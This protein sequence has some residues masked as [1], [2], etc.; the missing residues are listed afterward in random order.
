MNSLDPIS[1]AYRLQDL[2][3]GDMPDKQ[4]F[5]D[6]GKEGPALKDV[7]ELIKSEKAK[8]VIV[9]SCLLFAANQSS[10]FSAAHWRRSE[11]SG[12]DS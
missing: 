11:Y 5:S 12:R 4:V 9:V 2:E 1:N 6:A 3:S 7:A 8:R 10:R